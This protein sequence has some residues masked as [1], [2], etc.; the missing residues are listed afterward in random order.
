MWRNFIVKLSPTQRRQLALEE[1]N[2]GKLF[3][4]ISE[5]SRNKSSHCKFRNVDLPFSDLDFSFSVLAAPRS[6]VV[7][8]DH[9]SKRRM[10]M[11]AKVSQSRVREV[12]SFAFSHRQLFDAAKP[13]EQP[14]PPDLIFVLGLIWSKTSL[15]MDANLC[16]NYD[17][18]LYKVQ[19]RKQTFF[20]LKL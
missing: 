2:I 14:I 11:K 6:F 8:E 4:L 9:A 18:I 1:K 16:W 15:N 7:V 13:G 3:W 5:I 17:F 10:M 19:Y 12:R 20:P